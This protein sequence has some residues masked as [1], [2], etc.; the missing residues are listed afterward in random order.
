MWLA[1]SKLYS[2]RAGWILHSQK[3][4]GCVPGAG[5]MNREMG[6]IN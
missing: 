3:V 1:V 5:Y 4:V 2:T 6:E